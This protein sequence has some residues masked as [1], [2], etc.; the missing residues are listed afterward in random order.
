MNPSLPRL[1]RLFNIHCIAEQN[2]HQIT[3]LQDFVIKFHAMTLA[4]QTATDPAAVKREYM[5][6][7]FGLAG[8][9]LELCEDQGDQVF[10]PFIAAAHSLGIDSSRRRFRNLECSNV[11]GL[12]IQAGTF[13]LV[14]YGRAFDPTSP[15][16]IPLTSRLQRFMD[17]S[18]TCLVDFNPT[19]YKTDLDREYLVVSQQPPAADPWEGEDWDALPRLI[20]QLL[21]FMHGRERADLEEVFPVVWEREY[22]AGKGD[23]QAALNKANNFLLKRQSRETLHKR[24]GEG[25]IYWQ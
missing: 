18:Y 12:I 20:K 4:E 21:R 3:L 5:N 6:S 16:I 7:L 8:S 15:I 23:V 17:E 22:E 24:R 10:D 9:F 14:L 1:D 2:L 11:H 13:F 19:T 25:E